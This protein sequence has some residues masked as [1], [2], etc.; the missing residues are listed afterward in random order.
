M[1]MEMLKEGSLDVLGS[2][3]YGLLIF[4]L[5]ILILYIYKFLVWLATVQCNIC[6]FALTSAN[7]YRSYL[8]GP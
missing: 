7:V 6:R 1:N 3:Q 2:V 4:Q 8:E 5:H